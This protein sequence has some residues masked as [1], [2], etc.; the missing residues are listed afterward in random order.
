MNGK[1]IGFF[2]FFN[3][4]KWSI[5]HSYP[6]PFVMTSSSDK[7][8]FQDRQNLIQAIATHPKNWNLKQLSLAMGRNHAY[9]H[10]YIHR[11]SPKTLPEQDRYRLASLLQIDEARLRPE[12]SPHPAAG[13]TATI[14]AEIGSDLVTIGYVDHPSQMRLATKPWSIPASVFRR[15][16]SAPVDK[17]RLAVLGESSP[18]HIFRQGDVVILD[19]TDVS[20]LRAGY[21]A[22]DAGGQIRV[23]HIEQNS[24]GMTA[25]LKISSNG[26]SSYEIA[27]DAIPILGR[28]IFHSRSVEA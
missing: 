9:L 15:N 8:L 11:G 26:H 19:T 14:L 3:H 27:A 2:L 4:P 17:V 13:R 1:I 12:A 18:D 5:R 6:S 23:R 10:Q 20:P 25:L 16:S 22:F 28:V 21:F 24:N 7:S